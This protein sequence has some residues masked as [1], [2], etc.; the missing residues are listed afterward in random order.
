METI[1][2]EALELLMK[3]SAELKAVQA[4]LAGERADAIEKEKIEKIKKSILDEMAA[5]KGKKVLYSPAPEKPEADTEYKSFREFLY[6]VKDKNPNLIKSIHEKTAMSTTDAQGGYTIP[7]GYGNQ[8]VNE[9]Q[10][11]SQLVGLFTPVTQKE[12][13]VKNP[14]LATTVTVRIST[15]ATA[16]SVT[17]PTFGQGDLALKFFYAII[18]E[19]NELKQGTIVNLDQLIAKEVATGLALKI[20]DEA[21][22]GSTFTGLST[23]GINSADQIGGNLDYKDLTKCINNSSQLEIYKARSSWCLNRLAMNMIMDL[24]DSN[25]RPLWNLINPV[26]GAVQMVL[27]G[28]PVRFSDQIANPAAGTTIYFGDFSKIWLGSREGKAGLDVLYSETAVINTGGSITENFFQDNMA[29]WRFE[30]ENSIW[31]AV[32]A[33]FVKIAKVK[34]A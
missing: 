31:V 22:E 17:K 34:T 7:T 12:T 32:P 19:T 14:S 26:Q 3:D 23:A 30:K 9:I 20:E 10:N 11:Q 21:L 25:K 6:A 8:I 13:T 2:K 18:T 27:L 16:K 29:G 1:G 5:P 4:K 15:E 24:E 33:A 28:Y